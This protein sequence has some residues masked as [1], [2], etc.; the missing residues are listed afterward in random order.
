MTTGKLFV[1]ASWAALAAFAFGLC[2]GCSIIT[3]G[4]D[5]L[6]YFGCLALSGALLV[7]VLLWTRRTVERLATSEAAKE[8]AGQFLWSCVFFS[9]LSCNLGI[10]LLAPFW[11]GAD[12]IRI[13]AIAWM[14]FLTC[15]GTYPVRRDAKRLVNAT[16]SI[17]SQKCD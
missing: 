15:V 2:F 10:T 6:F 13:L 14:G 4:Y 8:S 7:V 9:M 3:T 16:L 17:A 5:R 11:N 12:F 1:R